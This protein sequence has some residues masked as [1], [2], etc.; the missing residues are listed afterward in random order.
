VVIIKNSRDI[1]E[2]I[3]GTNKKIQEATQYNGYYG[4]GYFGYNS[5]YAPS[6]N[7]QQISVPGPYLTYKNSSKLDLARPSLI[8]N[9]IIV[10]DSIVL[11]S[12]EKQ[13]VK[14][15]IAPKGGSFSWEATGSISVEWASLKP[16]AYIEGLEAGTGYAKVTY[17]DGGKVI[18][19]KIKVIVKD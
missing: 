19:K 11:N 17:S 12:G 2:N 10:P 1:A 8:E 4:Y 13:E 16:T 6:K 18:M 7:R 3:S 14:P 15:F 5:Y 9:N